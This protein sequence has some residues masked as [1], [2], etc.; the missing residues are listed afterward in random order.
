[1]NPDDT[2][3]PALERQL[4]AASYDCVVIGGGLRIPPES[5]LLFEVLVNAVHRAAPGVPIA[6][7]TQPRDTGDA[8]A[9]WLKG[10]A[11]VPPR[12]MTATATQIGTAHRRHDAQHA[13]DR[14][15]L[16]SQRTGA[17]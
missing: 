4:A 10:C 9:R 15:G 1:V 16:G 2:A 5:L 8:A 11:S 13:A 6:F 17:A 12:R 3:G 7:N 14:R